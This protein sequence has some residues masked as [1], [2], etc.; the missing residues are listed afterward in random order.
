MK[1]DG[2][3]TIKYRRFLLSPCDYD[4][5]TKV[6]KPLRGTRYNTRDELIRVIGRSIRTINKVGLPDG[7]RRL[8]N[9]WGKGG[10]YI[11]GA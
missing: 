7:L 11:E 2:V 5:F 8:P 6:K 4:R 1:N 10:D 9:I 3:S